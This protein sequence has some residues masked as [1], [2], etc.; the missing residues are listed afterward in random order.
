MFCPNCQIALIETNQQSV[1]VKGCDK[2]RGIWLD[3]GQ[4]EKI[5]EFSRSTETTGISIDKGQVESSKEQIQSQQIEQNTQVEKRK[6]A[7]FLSGAFDTK[8]DW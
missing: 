4:L 3:V 8:D 6:R 5:I 7:H 1:E 2:C